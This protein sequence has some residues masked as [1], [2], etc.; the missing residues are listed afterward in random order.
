MSVYAVERVRQIMD[1]RVNQALSPLILNAEAAER[2]ESWFADEAS[3]HSYRRELAFMAL[4]GLLRDDA[5]T[6]SLAGNVKLP[7]WERA[8]ARVAELRASGGLPELDYPASADWVVPW[9]YASTYILGQYAHGDAVRPG[10]VFFDCGACCGETAVWA[11]G[12]GAGQV[13]AFEPNP[14]AFAYLGRNVGKFGGGRIVPV[15][16]GL[17]EAPG[18][19]SMRTEDGNIGGTRFD[20]NA[21]GGISVPIVTLDGWCRENRV[22]PDFVKMD[23]EGWE[24]SAL[25]G[26]RGIIAECR[27][28]LAV[29]LYHS[30]SDMWAIP[31]L[32]KEICPSYRFW[33]RKNAPFAEFVLYAAR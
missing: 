18:L 21:K 7:D 8:L 14:D 26:G 2:V 9:M 19:M 23:L 13:Y 10:G 12:V 15:Q 33:C 25:R 5:A 32:L 24:M 4:R 20:P 11:L 6:V 3:R 17:G 27:P 31:H 30:L 16:R 28:R 29:C 22:R 1:C